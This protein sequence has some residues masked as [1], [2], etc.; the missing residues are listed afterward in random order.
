MRKRQLEIALS[1]LH[2]SPSPDIAFEAYDLDP[3]A[4]TEILFIA[5]KYQDIADRTI[6]DL[7]CGSGILAIGAAL[8]GGKEPFGIDINK[9]SIE[10]ARENARNLKVHLDL[11]IGDIAAVRGG[12][13]TSI[14][15][16]PFGTRRRGT[17]IMFLQRALQHSKVTYSLHKMTK[18]SRQFLLRA[19]EKMGGRVDA[20]FELEIGIPRTY[21]FHT[22]RSY[23]VAADLYRI[24]SGKVLQF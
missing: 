13:D 2:H 6:L 8:L 20:V 21:G 11:V 4:A 17:D 1:Q 5:E 15:N 12:F 18:A 9:E 22:K 10:T 24:I 7:G 3:N 19:I 14:M 16:P 23:S